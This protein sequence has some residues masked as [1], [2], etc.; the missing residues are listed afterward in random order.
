MLVV[1]IRAQRSN[2]GEP[3]RTCRVLVSVPMDAKKLAMLAVLLTEQA[4]S[5]RPGMTL[6]TPV[7][8]SAWKYFAG[9]PHMVLRGKKN[10]Q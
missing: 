9:R 3:S 2:R 6:T 1:Q 5:L 4:G 8:S 7:R 10:E